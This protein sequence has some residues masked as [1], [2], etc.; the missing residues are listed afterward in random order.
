MTHNFIKT[1]LYLRHKYSI[2]FP[3]LHRIS[4]EIFSTNK[5]CPTYPDIIAAL[6]KLCKN[7]GI[8]L[9]RDELPALNVDTDTTFA[10][11]DKYGNAFEK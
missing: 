11:K 8:Q 9:I 3:S 2:P 1:A 5:G 7:G 10:D 6:R 4:L